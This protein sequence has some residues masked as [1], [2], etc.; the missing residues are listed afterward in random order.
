MVSVFFSFCFHTKAQY[1]A[2]EKEIVQPL[3]RLA[4][5]ILSSQAK[6]FTPKDMENYL[7][8]KKTSRQIVLYKTSSSR[9]KTLSATEVYKRAL[10]AVGVAAMCTKPSPLHE[11]A[12]NPAT[13]FVI[14]PDGICVTNFHV[15][16]AYAHSKT[17][18]GK[19]VFL[20]RTGD[21]ETHELKSV[22]AVSPEDDIAII[23]LKS[24][25]EKFPFLKLAVSDASVGDDVYVLGNPEG[26][27]FNFTKGIVSNKYINT[28][29]MPGDNGIAHRNTM[30]IT[31]DFAVGSSG[32]PILND[33]GNVTGIVSSTYVI[34]QNNTGHPQSQMVIKNV[35]P[36]SSIKKL[37]RKI[38][39]KNN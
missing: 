8:D 19:G 5:S 16:Y 32:S 36:V 29:A 15:L 25:G 23:Q 28:I 30:V 12:M 11:A 33:K 2:A 21:G 34:E 17:F 13:A 24:S 38:E 6:I 37:I 20:V 1:T 22:L 26:L 3:K 31:A 39:A 9:K 7:K 14:T 4:D 18:G 27:F 35:I 10:Y